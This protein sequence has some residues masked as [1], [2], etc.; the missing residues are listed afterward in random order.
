[1]D[2]VPALKCC[3][4]CGLDKPTTE[5]HRHRKYRDGLRPECASC[6]GVKSR[7]RVYETDADRLWPRVEKR[8]EDECWPYAGTRT[9]AGYGK[10]HI[11]HGAWVRAHRLAWIVT[12]GQIPA[13]MEVCHECDNPPCCNPRH[14]FLGTHADN[15]ADM[16]LKGRANVA[17]GSAHYKAVINEDIAR[18]IRAAVSAGET[19]LA[20]AKRLGI[21]KNIVHQVVHNVT[22]KAPETSPDPAPE[23]SHL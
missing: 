4:K 7:A 16:S 17:V 20:V 13:E 14:L 15:M 19:Q 11:G 1:M 23:P 12:N 18:E 9:A 21:S 10:V 5:F 3:S 22:W 8:G 6:R 2:N